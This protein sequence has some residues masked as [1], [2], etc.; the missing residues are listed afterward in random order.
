MARNSSSSLP[1]PPDCPKEQFLTELVAG[2]L[3][4]HGEWEEI[5]LSMLELSNTRLPGME[6]GAALF[7]KV[8]ARGTHWRDLRLRDVRINGCDLANADWMGARF[9][10]VEVL[11]SRLTGLG[12]SESRLADVRFG[13]CKADATWF[14]NATFERA[15]FERC[16]LREANFEGADL[17]GVVFVDCDL[18]QARFTG[19]RMQGTDLRGSNLQGIISDPDNLRGIIIEPMQAADLIP[20]LGITL[21]NRNS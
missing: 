20:V 5:Q 14:R 8:A 12:L 15:R 2:T 7:T 1:A 16:D 4:P 17:S 3:Q 9:H 13:N 6:I 18:R 21:R 10:R 19:A 11:D